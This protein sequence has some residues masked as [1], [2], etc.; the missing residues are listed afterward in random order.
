MDFDR[1]GCEVASSLKD[2]LDLA[3]DTQN[4]QIWIIGGGSVYTALLTNC[5]RAY[6]TKVDD[7]AEDADT[8]FQ[9]WTNCPPGR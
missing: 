4:D 3:A 1:D 2:A 7:A 9:T 8:F 6:L 5:N